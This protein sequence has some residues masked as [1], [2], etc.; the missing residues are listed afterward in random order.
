MKNDDL[1]CQT[2]EMITHLNHCC[3]SSMKAGKDAKFFGAQQNLQNALLVCRRN[4]RWKTRNLK[5]PVADQ[6]NNNPG[7]VMLINIR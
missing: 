6:N 4:Q 7:L 1:M 5:V 2:H 3:V